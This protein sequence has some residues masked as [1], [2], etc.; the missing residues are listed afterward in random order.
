[1]QGADS[2]K[3]PLTRAALGAAALVV[4]LL[5]APAAGSA[6]E[7]DG[8]VCIYFQGGS[9]PVVGSFPCASRPHFVAID[10]RVDVGNGTRSNFGRVETEPAVLPAQQPRGRSAS[11]GPSGR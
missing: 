1:M 10:R 9:A 7:P 5:S 8:K 3:R 4:G 6:T 11:P 2:A